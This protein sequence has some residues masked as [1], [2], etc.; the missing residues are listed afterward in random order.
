MSR[1]QK[2]V[3]TCK[4][5]KELIDKEQAKAAAHLFKEYPKKITEAN[6]AVHLLYSI[7]PYYLNRLIVAARALKRIEKSNIEEEYLNKLSGAA[8][9]MVYLNES[10][11]PDEDW[12]EKIKSASEALRYLKENGGPDEASLDKLIEAAQ[13]LRELNESKAA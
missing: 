3:Y 1:L 2:D 4:G 9:A 6:E 7:N 8:K 11:G 12:M 5:F 13:A 10:E